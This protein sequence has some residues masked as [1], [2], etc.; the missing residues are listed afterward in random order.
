MILCVKLINMCNSLIKITLN[1]ETRAYCHY[2]GT[3]NGL[4]HNR[5][6][7]TYLLPS[8]QTPGPIKVLTHMI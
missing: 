4:C 5:S 3:D 8:A 7:F 1:I 6:K 2:S